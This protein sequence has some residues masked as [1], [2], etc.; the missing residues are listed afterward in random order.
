MKNN[1]LSSL[2]KGYITIIVL[3]S[4]PFSF[5]GQSMITDALTISERHY[6]SESGLVLDIEL[7]NILRKYIDKELKEYTGNPFIE[8]PVGEFASVSDIPDTPLPNEN[9]SNFLSTPVTTA[10]D[11]FA[12]FL[13]TRTKTELS[14]AFFNDFKEKLNEEK[15]GFKTLFPASALT[16]RSLDKDV[17]RFNAYMNGLRVAFEADLQTFP[18]NMGQL[19][20][21]D[22]FTKNLN[23]KKQTTELVADLL[24][25]SQLMM[26]KSALPEVLEF[27]DS[28]SN[29]KG[30]DSNSKIEKNLRASL[31]VANLISQSLLSDLETYTW[32][33]PEKLNALMQDSIATNIY[34]GLLWQKGDHIEFYMEKRDSSISFRNLLVELYDKKKAAQEEYLDQIYYVLRSGEQLDAKIREIKADSNTKNINYE[35]YHELITLTLDVMEGFM[36]FNTPEL[37]VQLKKDL[38]VIRSLT[39]LPL[40]IKRRQY[41]AAIAN[42]TIAMDYILEDNAKCSFASVFFKYASFIAAIAEAN[43][44]DQVAAIIEA[45]ALPPGSASIKKKTQWNVA[46]NSYVGARGAFR[47]KNSNYFSVNAPIGIAFSA[48]LGKELAISLY[49]SIIDIGAVTVFRFS[50]DSIQ[51]PEITLDNIIAP[52]VH[53]IIAIP[54]VP[55]SIGGGFQLS[56]NLRGID[57]QGMLTVEPRLWQYSLFVAVDIPVLNIYS[58]GKS[59]KSCK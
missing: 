14:N 23:L 30:I 48:S 36:D 58:S 51:L 12:K 24:E 21:E 43:D 27:L 5:I 55:I 11:G 35:K 44:S 34:L 47:E 15:Y 37:N 53:A 3:I 6:D 52:G 2:S 38:D 8:F 32:T 42:A 4:L 41:T 19:M 13:V 56:P 7:A 10:V 59:L 16:L 54:K 31:Q 22:T 25:A 17:Y 45:F 50:S 18:F 46:L 26:D 57:G 1:Y 20:R 28:R 40:H 9:L 49:P 33:Y 39:Y 29:S